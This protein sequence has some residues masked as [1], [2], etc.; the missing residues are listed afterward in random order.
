MITTRRAAV[1]G[2]PVTH[3]LSP[4]IHSV[5]FAEI[6][7]DWDYVAI[8][9]GPD[10]VGDVCSRLRTGDLAGLSVTMPLKEVIIAHLDAT[11]D[12]A[13]TLGAVNCVSS[14]EGRLIGHNTDGDG[15][16]DALAEQGGLRIAGST[17]LVLGAGGTARSVALALAVRGAR[18]VVRNR[19]PENTQ[20][21]LDSVSA[22]P[23]PLAGSVEEFDQESLRGSAGRFDAIVNATSVGMNSDEMPLEPEMISAGA[24]VL[25]AVYTPL[26]TRLLR[27]AEAR[28]ARAVDGLWMLIHQARHQEMIWFGV[29]G[30]VAAMRAESERVLAERSK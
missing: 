9:A 1:V 28:G 12:V 8:E 14:N 21:L 25:D 19:T 6:G 17:V 24:V 2:R 18:V 22:H 16:C 4:S 15:C 30:S 7:V 10:D 27:E 5:A 3:S 23:G 26:K 13:G 29:A 11:S 20:R